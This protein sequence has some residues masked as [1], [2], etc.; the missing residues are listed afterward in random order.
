MDNDPIDA[1]INVYVD[2][3]VEGKDD[4]DRNVI[5]LLATRRGEIWRYLM[6]DILATH[7]YPTLKDKGGRDALS[8]ACSDGEVDAVDQLIRAGGSLRTRDKTNWT[9][10]HHAIA[11]NRLDVLESLTL[12]VVRE[13]MD[14]FTGPEFW[15]AVNSN[16]VSD[17]ML[18][19]F[20]K[21]LTT[22]LHTQKC[23]ET[24][25]NSLM[26]QL[27][28]LKRDEQGSQPNGPSTSS[29]DPEAT[30]D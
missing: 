14:D 11:N 27:D 4:N 6:G 20:M 25:R 17:D 18:R 29:G 13:W 16:G 19:F 9:P 24:V 28:K 7:P 10:L 21:D 26:R 15:F 8:W 3:A 5:S 30:S 23:P 12:D 22:G 2:K 1:V